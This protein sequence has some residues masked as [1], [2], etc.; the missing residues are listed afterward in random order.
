MSTVG[1][2]SRSAFPIQFYLVIVKPYSR[3]PVQRPV[4]YVLDSETVIGEWAGTSWSDV[5]AK[6]ALYSNDVRPMHPLYERGE[7]EKV[8]WHKQNRIRSLTGWRWWDDRDRPHTVYFLRQTLSA[9]PEGKRF[10]AILEF[11]NYV[12]SQ[13]GAPGSPVGMLNGLLRISLPSTLV[14]SCATAPVDRLWRGSRVEA[15]KGVHTEY[16]PTDLWDMRS[17]FPTAFREV[18]VPRRWEH[19]QAK[20]Q[21]LLPDTEAAFVRAIVHV[22]WMMYGPLPDVALPHPNF[23]IGPTWLRGVWSIDELRSAEAAGCD[24]FVLEYWT[25]D[26]FRHPFR[27]WGTLVDELRASVGKDAVKLV[28][29][30]ANRYV[31]KFAMDG[32]RER[33][34]MIQGTETWTVERGHKRPESLAVHGL[35]TA[36]VRAHLFSE[37]IYPYPAHFVFCHTDGVALD[38]TSEAIGHPPDG[39][40]SVKAYMERLLLINPQRYAYRPGAEDREPGDW[41]YVVAGVPQPGAEGF[42]ATRWLKPGVNLADG[43]VRPR[44]VREEGERHGD[45]KRTF[46]RRAAT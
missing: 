37:G 5:P 39:R 9:I 14:E 17:A 46:D 18:P 15:R 26:H 12:R 3:G 11:V 23:P 43:I 25:A 44:R 45:R 31:G 19:Y 6:A 32:H 2:A 28:K 20:G 1:I 21:E 27:E 13:G 8:W 40:W 35:V 33:S 4:G 38:A 10:P 22:P 34:R 7:C 16:G 42:F 36:G 41:R 24:V 29:M 30:A